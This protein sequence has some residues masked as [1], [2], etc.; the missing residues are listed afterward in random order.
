MGSSL[1]TKPT[2]GMYQAFFVG[3]VDQNDAPHAASLYISDPMNN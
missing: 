2:Q 3:S 1:R